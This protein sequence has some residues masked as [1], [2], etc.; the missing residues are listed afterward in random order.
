MF[1]IFLFK[2]QSDEDVIYEIDTENEAYVSGFATDH[3]IHDLSIGA[4][5]NDK[6]VTS[7]RANNYQSCLKYGTCIDLTGC[8]RIPG[9]V[10]KICNSAF[11]LT[12]INSVIFEEGLEEIQYAAFYE[13][14]NL[15]GNLNLPSTL[16]FLG[17]NC[18]A[19][20]GISFISFSTCKF[21]EISDSAFAQMENL[22]YISEF[23]ETLEKISDLAFESC[24][25]LKGE[26][27]HFSIVSD[28]CISFN[29]IK[30]NL[31]LGLGCFMYCRCLTRIVF[32]EYL[33]KI[34][35][36]TFYETGIEQI[37][38]DYTNVNE[39]P[40]F[41][42]G[43]CEKLKRI[44]FDSVD[45]VDFQAFSGLNGATISTKSITTL[46]AYSFYDCFNIRLYSKHIEKIENR[47]FY[48][49]S[50]EEFEVDYCCSIESSA[51]Y[52][53]MIKNLEINAKEITENAFYSCDFSMFVF[54]CDV[55]YIGTNVFVA[56]TDL[57]IIDF[58]QSD[59]NAPLEIEDSAFSNNA[60]NPI[61]FISNP[62]AR[63]TRIGKNAFKGIF[64][65]KGPLIL[66][67]NLKELGASA[68]E[69]CNEIIGCLDFSKCKN[70]N[71]INNYAFFGCTEIIEKLELP[72]SLTEIGS[73]AFSECKFT[74][75]I[76]IPDKVTI[77]RENAFYHCIYFTGSIIIGS[78]VS[79]IGA[80][81]FAECT[82]LSGQIIFKNYNNPNLTRIENSTF[83]GCS[84]LKGNLVLPR[85][86]EVISEFAFFN[87]FGFSNRLNLSE[88]IKAIGSSAFAFCRFKDRLI[89]PENVERI[90]DNAFYGCRNLTEV[91]F[92]GK[93]TKIGYMA[94]GHLNIRYMINI[95]DQYSMNSDYY[96]T[97]F[98]K[99]YTKSWL[100]EHKA[101]SII[102]QILVIGGGSIV[103]LGI[104]KYVIS[105]VALCV[106]S[107]LDMKKHFTVVFN[108]IIKKETKEV[109]V[110]NYE[111]SE[112]KWK[113]INN[114]N[115]RMHKESEEDDFKLTNSTAVDLLEKSIKDIWPTI[116]PRDSHD[117]V[118]KSF[119]GIEF[120]KRCCCKCCLCNK[121]ETDEIE[122][123]SSLL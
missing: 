24:T 16:K 123:T 105:S 76:D 17:F 95:P 110:N 35:M 28:C 47:A 109:D 29:T 116:L 89:I 10:K 4:T 39:I 46:R 85:S 92:K 103:C 94:F 37:S 65:K 99:W 74:G 78:S 3:P 9:T 50:F 13:C 93:N 97:D 23:P 96:D 115:E 104:S 48:N 114:I 38:L 52:R 42:F 61:K 18:F 73:Y 111:S 80:F 54:G 43:N 91:E 6:N 113:I 7:I 82:G 63:T 1:F 19:R 98:D 120:H 14:R 34:D 77:I 75:S 66:P 31:T 70:L 69:G 55:E 90:G 87:C 45:Y 2:V 44:S 67:R 8:L 20:T 68:F 101:F 86:I 11:R 112:I 22:E 25:R 81:A 121:L 71:K 26:N 102:L 88:R 33:V 56:C 100:K 27:S 51:F 53:F 62:P 40:S 122:L 21:T 49:S 32:P 5:F 84:N 117:I 72:E 60:I 12:N 83:F 30:N 59:S 41:C 108:E 118:R 58:D 15:S 119:E 107:Y 36:Y 57:A 106:G 64:S 79:S